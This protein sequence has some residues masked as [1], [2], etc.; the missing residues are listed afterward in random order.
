[1]AQTG[2]SYIVKLTCTGNMRIITKGYTMS[3]VENKT[4]LQFKMITKSGRTKQVCLTLSLDK[5]IKSALVLLAKKNKLSPD[6]QARWI[7]MTK[8]H[9]WDTFATNATFN[10]RSMNMEATKI[11][12]DYFSSIDTSK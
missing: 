7:I 2:K 11:I 3:S 6:L 8:Y 12:T 10:F 1:M 4:I 5:K 9:N